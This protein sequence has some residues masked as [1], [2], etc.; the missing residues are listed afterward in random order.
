MNVTDKKQHIY[1]NKSASCIQDQSSVLQ[2]CKNQPKT[3]VANTDL[4][5]ITT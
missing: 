3:S 2:S 5:P 4:H 1:Y